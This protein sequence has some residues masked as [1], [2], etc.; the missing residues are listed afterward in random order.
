MLTNVNSLD[1]PWPVPSD[2]RKIYD[3]R[4]GYQQIRYLWERDGWSYEA[5]WHEALPTAT[6]I[7]YPSWQ[8]SRHFPGKG[9][10]PDAHH[11]KDEIWAGDKWIPYQQVRYAARCLNN[12]Q[13]TNQQITLLKS[14]HLVSDHL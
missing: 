3:H 9:Y 13:A 1:C 14:T 10:G 7:T 11:K 6:L 2:A 4:H 8:L 5:R 12:D